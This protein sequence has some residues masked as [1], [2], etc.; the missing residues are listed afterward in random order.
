M[1]FTVEFRDEHGRY[2]KLIVPNDDDLAGVVGAVRDRLGIRLDPEL[3]AA[4][5]RRWAALQAEWHAK[6]VRK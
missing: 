3:E 6:K 4:E 2:A 5:N 1:S